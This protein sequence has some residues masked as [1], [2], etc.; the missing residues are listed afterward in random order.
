MDVR[1]PVLG[2]HPPATARRA[3]C[4][5]R[6]VSGDVAPVHEKLLAAAG[7]RNVWIVGGGDLVGQFADVGCWTR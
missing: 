3:R 4:R 2:V 5:D 7:D 6:F 1:R